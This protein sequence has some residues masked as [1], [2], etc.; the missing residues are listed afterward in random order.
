MVIFDTGGQQSLPPLLS[1][2]PSHLCRVPALPSRRRRHRRRGRRSGRLVRLKFYL[3]HCSASTGS[4]HGSFLG[5]GVS[6]LVP[7]V[8]FE[9]LLPRRPC[10]LW[11][12]MRRQ[13]L[14]NLRPLCRVSRPVE[15]HAPA[16]VRIGLQKDVHSVKRL[17]ACLGDIKAWLALNFLNFNEKKTEV[18]VFGPSGSCESS[19]VD[20]GPL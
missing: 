15:A 14:R 12:N 11:L 1:E 6:C 18:M 7:V 3:S 5:L 19:S 17:Q 8:G 10:P 16:P 13:C 20:L 9:A 4:G 2:I